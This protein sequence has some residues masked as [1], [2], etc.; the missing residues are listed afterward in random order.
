MA[1]LAASYQVS[2]SHLKNMLIHARVA[3][4]LRMALTGLGERRELVLVWIRRRWQALELYNSGASWD[5]IGELIG[6]R[7]AAVVHFLRLARC[8]ALALDVVELLG[9]V[10]EP[11]A[12]WLR[13]MPADRRG[14]MELAAVAM[15]HLVSVPVMFRMMASCDW[16]LADGR[17]ARLPSV[18]APLVPAVA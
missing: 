9:P 4:G 16:H 7:S 13:G 17:L 12:D 1:E 14:L 11:L 2:V 10:A 3:T 8:D 5:C 6:I 15:G 18:D